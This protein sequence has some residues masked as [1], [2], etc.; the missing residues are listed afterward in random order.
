M[1]IKPTIYENLNPRERLVAG[2]EALARKDE[3]EWNKLVDTCPKLTYQQE[4]L[5]F[6][7]TFRRLTSE[8]ISLELLLTQQIF[9]ALFLLSHQQ[10]TPAIRNLQGASNLLAA[11]NEHLEEFGITP[12]SMH[13]TVKG[14]RDP[15]VALFIDERL[16]RLPPPEPEKVREYKEM[17]RR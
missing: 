11:W 1:N 9:T 13:A 5:A 10:Y 15:C 3:D 17:W 14:L 6:F 7:G 2:I 16:D 4:D 8:A 12:E